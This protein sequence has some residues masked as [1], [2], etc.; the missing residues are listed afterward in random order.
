MHISLFEIAKKHKYSIGIA[1]VFVAAFLAFKSIQHAPSLT[2]QQFDTIPRTNTYTVKQ[3]QSLQKSV[4]MPS[5]WSAIAVRY[6]TAPKQNNAITA[7]LTITMNGQTI[8][9]STT[10]TKEILDI[11]SIDGQDFFTDTSWLLFPIPNIDIDQNTVT[12][13]ITPNNGYL[14]VPDDKK[15]SH[16]PTIVGFVKT[17]FAQRLSWSLTYNDRLQL[18]ITYLLVPI[19]LALT[20]HIIHISSYQN[21]KRLSLYLLA[22]FVIF[23]TLPLFTHTN[24]W[25]KND[26][27]EVVAHFAAARLSFSNGQFPLWNPYFCGG[28][29][30]WS[31]PQTYWSSGL[32]VFTALTDDVIGTKLAIFIYLSLGLWG[33][34]ALCRLL[35][36]PPLSATTASIIFIGN[37]FIAMHLGVGHLL[38]LTMAWIP[39]VIFFF[40]KSIKQP[41]YIVASVI[42]SLCIF[43]EGQIYF[44]IYT[45]LFLG[46]FAL[47]W[48][49]H[50]KEHV[51]FKR[52]MLFGIL[53]ITLGAIKLLPT[54]SFMGTIT[55][56]FGSGAYLPVNNLYIS[57][58]ERNLTSV[59]PEYGAYIGLVAL[60]FF[61]IGALQALYTKNRL[62]IGIVCIGAVF[63]ALTC[64]PPWLNVQRSIPI[65]ADLRTQTRALVMVM[66]TV[67]ILAAYG[68]AWLL[69]HIQHRT[70][71]RLLAV[72]IVAWLAFD[73]TL[74][75]RPMFSKLFTEPTSGTPSNEGFHQTNGRKDST[76]HLVKAERG[77]INY[78]PPH[79]RLW[80]PKNALMYNTDS[81]YKGEVYTNNNSPI[82]LKHFTPNRLTIA[83]GTITKSDIVH[84]NQNYDIGWHS[85]EVQITPNNNHISFRITPADSNQTITIEYMPRGFL[86]GAFVTTSTIL[87]LVSV[88][89][90]S[91]VRS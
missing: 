71:K 55:N 84:V 72:V 88:A 8:A 3:G 66:L 12:V 59:D 9:T 43:I 4:F 50:T 33:M 49:W 32:F 80:Q 11:S 87:V 52:L 70:I 17:N 27:T 60:L 85:N 20:W 67:S 78:C 23:F 21:M 2:I 54:L 28:F 77:N 41:W 31:N 64:L 15:K 90:W 62:Y 57:F 37:G 46:L 86:I 75:S 89:V 34:Y 82:S 7:T 26:W 69:T 65:L 53:V 42:T 5:R 16:D 1:L 29:P 6:V 44:T 45:F 40:I 10:S 63:L 73:Y 68:M 79:I 36:L 51:F 24:L 47:V 39:W 30:A 74:V 25:G 19:A 56:H 58:L 18:Y 14:V 81:A 22:L 13:H 91:R 83:L 61:T 35:R 76:Y 48:W 38:W